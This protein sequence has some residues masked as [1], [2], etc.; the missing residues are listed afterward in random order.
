MD[1]GRQVCDITAGLTISTVMAVFTPPA[2]WKAHGKFNNP[3]PRADFNKIKMAPKDPSRGGSA[4]DAD[5]ASRLM[6]SR[7]SSSMILDQVWLSYCVTVCAGDL[8]Q[9]VDPSPQTGGTYKY[10]GPVGQLTWSNW[11]FWQLTILLPG[12]TFDTKVSTFAC[13]HWLC[14]RPTS[15][16][17]TYS[18]EVSGL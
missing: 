14:P 15:A 18:T 5:R 17:P 6:L 4:W 1:R 9:L 13:V 12:E 11:T 10:V 7:A 2:F 16:P 3:A 8:V